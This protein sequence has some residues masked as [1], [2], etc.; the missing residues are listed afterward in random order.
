MEEPHWVG[1]M[2]A[3]AALDI[4][5]PTDGQEPVVR[6]PFSLNGG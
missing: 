2:W 3:T 4:L 6:S 5:R 1:E